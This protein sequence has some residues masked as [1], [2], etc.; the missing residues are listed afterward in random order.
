MNKRK[1]VIIF[2]ISI[3]IS[4]ENFAQTKVDSIP[5]SEMYKI[6]EQVKTPYK[7]GLVIAPLDNDKKV[8]CPSVFRSHDKWFMTYLIFNG[9]GYETWLAQSDDLLH[10]QTKGCIMSFSDTADWD[11]NQKAG[12]VALENFNWGSDYKWQKYSGRYW[13]SYFGGP[14]RGYEKNPLYL[15]MAYTSKDPSIAHEWTR[16]PKPILTTKDSNVSWWDNHTQYKSTVIWDKKKLT[17]YSF[18]MYYNANG[19]SLNEKRGAERIGMAVS[20]D[21]LH[22]KR[23]GKDPVLNHGAGI[24][25]DPQIQK[26]GDVYVMFYFGAFWNHSGQVFNTFA[27]SYDLVHWTDWKGTHLIEASEPYDNMFAHKSFVVKWKETVYH[28]YCA[29]DKAGQRGIAV[30]TSKDLGKS[31]VNFVVPPIK[32]KK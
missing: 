32:N 27:C 5:Q 8:D 26:I 4:K 30:A 25:G 16:L 31:S 15:G 23:F 6:Y 1:I 19:D 14:S 22:W 24:T 7:Y 17:G 12:Y 29:V 28:F 20:D 9:R 2:L 21:M 13:M 10:W 11:C 18:I 3:I